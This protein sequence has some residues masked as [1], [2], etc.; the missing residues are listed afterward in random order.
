MITD[1]PRLLDDQLVVRIVN[2][3]DQLTAANSKR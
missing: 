1:G 3:L 2:E